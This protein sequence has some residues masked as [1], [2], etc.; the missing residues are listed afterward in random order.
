VR[1]HYRWPY[2]YVLDELTWGQLFLA[3]DDAM[4]LLVKSSPFGGGESTSTDR[5]QTNNVSELDDAMIAARDDV[6]VRNA[7]F[8][9]LPGHLRAMLIEEGITK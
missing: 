3:Y 1:A 5:S 6:V 2:K 7:Q 4:R 9:S 8:E